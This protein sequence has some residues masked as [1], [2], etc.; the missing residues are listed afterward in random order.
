VGLNAAHRDILKQVAL[1]RQL[2]SE[3]QQL[4]AAVLDGRPLA[5]V[6]TE[7]R[8]C[9]DVLEGAARQGSSPVR[10]ATELL[11]AN[12]E[13]VPWLWHGYLAR[14]ET[15]LLAGLPKSGKSTLLWHLLAAAL[16]GEPEFA[17]QK[18]ANVGRVLVLTEESPRLVSERLRS[19]GVNNDRLL[20]ALRRDI[21]T[22]AAVHSTI[23]ACARGGLDVVVV[24]TLAAF[25]ALDD[26]NDA[27]E[28]ERKVRPLA[29]LAQQHSFALLLTHHLRKSP[30][31]DG[32][33]ARGSTAIVGLVDTLLE[34]HRYGG[35]G[36][37]R[38]R[39][40]R[41]I[42]RHNETPAE[43]VLELRN[44][45]YR[46]L[47]TSSRAAFVDLV[48]ALKACLPEPD[49]EG[50]T[51]RELRQALADAG[52]N[53]SHA[54]VA[55]AL[56]WLVKDGAVERL[57]RGRG[58]DPYRYR[59]ARGEA[60]PAGTEA[61][62]RRGGNGLSNLRE[63]G[64]GQTYKLSNPRSYNMDKPMDKPLSPSGAA[65]PAVDPDDLVFEPEEEETT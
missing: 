36:G 19:F 44:E 53:A 54:S 15:T 65:A 43:I 64:F 22:P 11:A 37:E 21:P 30:G 17:G 35:Q 50:L 32:M 48:K 51:E 25:A 58:S 55:R 1:R 4:A 56:D 45:G 13:D 27:A 61:S 31:D 38:R 62:I 49:D 3:A 40:L 33:Q 39:R 16:S 52:H 10:T 34:L 5:E 46:L 6:V 57:G 18:L 63:L 9:L 60:H 7:A 26:E 8:A 12:V 42:G 23:E 28:I 59:L 41:G 20:V 47:G 14:G 29:L 24:D 2:F